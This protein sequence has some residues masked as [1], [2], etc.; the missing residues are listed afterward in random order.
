MRISGEARS[1]FGKWPGEKAIRRQD[2][3]CPR[4]VTGVYVIRDADAKL[5]EVVRRI[6][7]KFNPIRIILFGSRARSEPGPDSDADLLVVMAVRGSRRKAATE[8]DLSLVG[9]DMPIDVIVVTPEDVERDRGSF[10]TLIRT[11]LLEGR[12]LHERGA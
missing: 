2:A 6:V 5:N 8:V 11:A 12:V 10:G 4:K 7:A 9:V 1:F 3:C